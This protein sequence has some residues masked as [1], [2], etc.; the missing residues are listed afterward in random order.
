MTSKSSR[1]LKLNSSETIEET[2]FTI[3]LDEAL[4]LDEN[5]ELVHPEQ[6][7]G[8]E[9]GND[10]VQ[11]IDNLM[12]REPYLGVSSQLRS[13]QEGVDQTWLGLP[14]QQQR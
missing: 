2:T 4:L 11:W 12:A 7:D 6:L 14:N 10:A 5:T 3:A 9:E 1:G 13:V 8:W